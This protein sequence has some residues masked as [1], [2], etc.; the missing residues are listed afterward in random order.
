M[1]QASRWGLP[2]PI[3]LGSSL[4]PLRLPPQRSKRMWLYLRLPN[5]HQAPLDLSGRPPHPIRGGHRHLTGQ[6]WMVS[7]L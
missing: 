4:E 3:A 2:G 6:H 7:G 1:V 5:T